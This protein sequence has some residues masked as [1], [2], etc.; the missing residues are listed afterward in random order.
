MFQL[1]RDDIHRI[2][3]SSGFVRGVTVHVV[4][5]PFKQLAH[6]AR[7]TIHRLFDPG[8]SALP[9]AII[10]SAQGDV[11][12]NTQTR[13]RCQHFVRRTCEKPLLPC[14]KHG[15]TGKKIVNRLCERR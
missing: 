8:K 9:R 4:P 11:S 5:R 12:M 6:Q 15:N 3:K 14:T 1:E 2:A 7:C 10:A 13:E